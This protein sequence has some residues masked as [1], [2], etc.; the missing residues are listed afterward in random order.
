[1]L[2]TDFR[3]SGRESESERE[4]EKERD[5]DIDVREIF[6][7]CLYVPWPGNKPQ[8][9][10]VPDPG[11]EPAT[12]WCTGRQS[13]QLSHLARVQLQLVL[14]IQLLKLELLANNSDKE[15]KTGQREDLTSHENIS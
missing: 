1:M 11:T 8:P 14:T 12:C 10:Y 5:K 13:T 7:G 3:K 4:W 15:E 2:F 6:I 9:M